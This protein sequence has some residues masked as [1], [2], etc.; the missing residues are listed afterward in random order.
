MTDSDLDRLRGYFHTGEI[1]VATPH[2]LEAETVAALAEGTLDAEARARAL[3]HVAT[4]LHCRGAVASV[5][6]ALA[7]GPITHEIDVVE[8]RRR[9]GRPVLRV[10]VPLAAAATVLLLLWSPTNDTPGMH[11]GVGTQNRDVVPVPV[12]PIGAVANVHSL[13]WTRVIGSDRYRVTLFD[14][15]GGVLYEREVNDTTAALPDSVRL[16]PGQPYLWKVHARTGWDRWSASEL[17]EFTIA[18]G[19]PQ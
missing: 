17:V 13:T 14:A 15:R 10:A 3:K 11:R 19:P 7:D 5:T 8:G 2:C 18:R 1:P 6:A 4:C 9:R 16:I 12:G